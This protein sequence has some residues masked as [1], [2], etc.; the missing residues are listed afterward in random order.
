MKEAKIFIVSAPS[1][2]GKTTLMADVLMH[3]ADFA[4]RVITC[5]TRPP[6]KGEENGRD[7]WF[8]DRET[9]DQKIE[10]GEFLEVAT[11]YGHKYGV[12]FESVEETRKRGKHAVLILDVQGAKSV[13][14]QMKAVTLFIV[15][16][17]MEELERRIRR[18][19]T[20]GEKEIQRRLAGAGEEMKERCFY[21]YLIVNDDFSFASLV[22]RSIIIAETYKNEDVKWRETSKKLT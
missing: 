21:D 11:V 18:R 13:C 14:E 1:G 20:D 10:K 6:R 16:P 12:L 9:F 17:S 22:I 3:L 15:P 7:Y 8:F 2:A 4:E 19:H 5:T